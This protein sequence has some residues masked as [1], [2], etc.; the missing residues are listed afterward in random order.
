MFFSRFVYAVV[1]CFSAF[2][3]ASASGSGAQSALTTDLL[4]SLEEIATESAARQLLT[5]HLSNLKKIEA[6]VV[7]AIVQRQWWSL[8]RDIVAESHVQHVDLSFGVRKAVKAL[9]EEADE[10][11]RTLNPKYGLAQ[12]VSPAFQWAQNDTC[13]VL[14]IKYT[15]RWNAPGALEA[16]DISV[17]MSEASFN[18]TGLGKHSNNK[19]KY[20][21][22]LKLFD[23]I[24]EEFSTWSA[25]SVGKLSVTLRKRWAR[26]WP[27]LLGDK[28]MKIGNMHLWSERQEKLDST[29]TNMN[30]VSN[31]PVTCQQSEKLYCLPTDTCKKADQCGTCPGKNVPVSATSTCAGVPVEKAG[32]SFKDSDMDENEL[33]GTVTIHKARNEFDI[34]R[35]VVFFGKDDQTKLE[36]NDWKTMLVGEA[37]P[38]G[39]DVELKIAQNTPLPAGATHLLVYS[40]NAHGDY[41]KPGSVVI[42]DAELPRSKPTQVTFDDED[43][44]KGSIGGNVVIELPEE[45]LKVDDYVV[46]W[47]RSPTRKVSTSSQINSMPADSQKKPSLTIY[48]NRGTK[49]AE[50]ATHLLVFAKNAHGEQ[51]TGAS[52]KLVDNMKPC[53]NRTA[54]SCPGGVAVDVLADPASKVRATVR[55]T[56]A[57]NEAQVVWYSLYWGRTDC[58]QDGQSGAKNGHIKDIAVTA[59]TTNY[60][61]P[62]DVMV[63]SGSGH[64]LVFSKN[65]VG[66]STYCVSAPF[67]DGEPPA[68]PP[69]RPLEDGE[70]PAPP[71]L[72][73]LED[74]PKGEL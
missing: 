48:I 55:V 28:K 59:E 61:I 25:A 18:F 47:G 31:S 13:I 2:G 38:V 69:L 65:K 16:T 42:V 12:Q 7:E 10:L 17:N 37:T 8:A 36:D 5:P 63:P 33:G 3:F 20:V 57:Q 1:G 60:D 44:E 4:K 30:A 56:R 71:P 51:V 66:E 49:I 73:P 19:Y 52:V 67:Q 39:A 29:L 53:R 62:V 15:V 35:Y 32:L 50:G 43:G 21:L 23:N 70:S 58:T 41:D 46:H 40:Q 68:P 27:R 11:L 14:T 45:Q 22:S 9:K 54:R 24:V 34:D 72:R 74:A 6:P 64:I 26:K